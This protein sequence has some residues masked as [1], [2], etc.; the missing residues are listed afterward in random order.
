MRYLREIVSVSSVSHVLQT[1]WNFAKSD[2]CQSNVP[3]A[4]PI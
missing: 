2:R 1:V 4:F 3:I